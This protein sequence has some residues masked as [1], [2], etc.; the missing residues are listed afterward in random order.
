MKRSRWIALIMML[1]V[2]CA[3]FVSAPV[4][5]EHPWDADSND[6][7]GGTG[8]GQT[9]VDTS[10]NPGNTNDNDVVQ[11]TDGA[12]DPEDSLFGW[13]WELM[14]E[15]GRTLVFG[16]STDNGCGGTMTDSPAGSGK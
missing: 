15:Y 7:T 5:A 12:A 16:S 8:P 6:G 2:L 11:H 13:L 1:S 3:C 10:Q 14:I 9:T 4:L